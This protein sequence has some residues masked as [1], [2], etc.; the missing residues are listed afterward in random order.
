[1]RITHPETGQSATVTDRQY[2][3]VWRFTGWLP[4]DP[5]APAAEPENSTIDEVLAAVGDD[6]A[7]AAAALD[8]EQA[9]KNR[10]TLIAALE[11]ITTPTDPVTPEALVANTPEEPTA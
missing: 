4:D 2:D 10:K 9:G 3:L 11:R 6:P 8:A 7:L 5:T 1:M